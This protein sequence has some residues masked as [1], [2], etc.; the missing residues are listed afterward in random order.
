MEGA[1][2]TSLVQVMADFIEQGLVE[3]IVIMFKRDPSLYPLTGELLRDPRF[4]VRMGVSIL[5]EDLAVVRPDD[6]ALAVPSLLPLL[7]DHTAHVRGE[8][9]NMLGIIGTE[10][11]LR[12]VARMVDDPDPQV[13]EIAR[14]ILSA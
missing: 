3:N 2:G 10:E 14:D 4:M 7:N 1:K 12:H 9:V 11:A 5:F 6:I 13:S 8:A